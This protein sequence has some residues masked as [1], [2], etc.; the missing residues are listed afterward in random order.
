MIDGGWGLPNATDR[1]GRPT[2]SPAIYPDLN[3]SFAPIGNAVH[4]AG[5]KF[6]LWWM[7]GVSRDAVARKLPVK[8]S[9]YTAAD[10]VEGAGGAD[11]L[12]TP[13]PSYG[14]SGSDIPGAAVGE[15]NLQLACRY[16]FRRILLVLCLSSF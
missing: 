9:P 4:Q 1:F 2:P 8:G 11:T 14:C 3:G 13:H 12:C 10:I 15:T 16:C 6:G 7:H 5:A